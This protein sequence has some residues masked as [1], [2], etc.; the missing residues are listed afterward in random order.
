MSKPREPS[1]DVNDDPEEAARYTVA[2]NPLVGLRPQDFIDG[3]Q[4]IL[5]AVASQP[6]IA[7]EHWLQFLGE[8][9]K[10]VTNKAERPID[11]A[12]KRFADPAWKSSWL[13][14]AIQQSYF[15]WADAVSAFVDKID[16][17]EQDRARAKLISSILVDAIAP[18]NSLLG[19]PAALKKFVD[20]GGKSLWTGFSQ[21][22]ADLKDNG[23]MPSQV[24]QTPFA[25]GKNLAT[26]PGAVVFRNTLFEL[27]Q[28]KPTTAEVWRQPLIITPP[29]INK[30][31]SLDLSPDKSLVRFLLSEGFQVFCISW[32]NPKAEHRDW[33][34]ADYVEAV[35]QAVDTACAITG[36]ETAA[37][38]GACSGGITA[39]AYAAREAARKK[40]KLKALTLAVC[41]LDPSTAQDT[42]LGAL[43]TPLTIEAA[44]RQSQ[45]AGLL[46]GRDLA[47]VF[48]WMRPNDLIWNYWVSNYLLGNR[49]PAFDILFWNND[50][51]S[52]PARLHSDYLNLITQNPFRN[53]GAFKLSGTPIDIGKVAVD[54]YVIAG[55][56]DHITP[57]KS[58]Y[59]SAR[60]LG[61]KTTFVLS[62]AGHLQAL[63][64]PP[65]NAKATY[66]TGAASSDDADAFAGAA[67]KCSGSWWP[68]WSQWLAERSGEKVPAAS[69]LG[70]ATF[71][72][73]E[74]APGTY[75]FNA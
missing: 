7:A 37:M 57:W 41:T 12:D 50:T 54:S 69:E 5:K 27:I 23:G 40:S 72:A 26:T 9:G 13:H 39:C 75:V 52:L 8:V 30:Y 43:I 42:V 22:L 49:P 11:P 31:Y 51:T 35:A 10:I 38:M 28:F 60:M 63:L 2:L 24:D 64:N 16:L 34:L 44:R 4:T 33:G 53:P 14:Y 3:A 45:Q 62:T 73:R 74:A 58:V 67:V 29:Q 55:L 48:A 61:D 1:P 18:T 36:S 21:Y 71:P 56:T 59:Q 15:A 66:A 68:H 47:K 25:V 20:T 65:G 70:N 19:N 6:T 32:R 46:N 17:A